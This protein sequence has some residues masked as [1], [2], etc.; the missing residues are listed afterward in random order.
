MIQH[1]D[2]H[3]GQIL[4][5][6]LPNIQVPRMAHGQKVPMDD[7][8]HGI[9]T[10]IIDLGLSRMDSDSAE[11]EQVHWTPLEDEIFEGEGGPLASWG[12][13]CSSLRPQVTTNL[14]YTE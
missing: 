5:K 1:R 8:A 3:W 4:V 14:T 11:V 12:D 10:T 13:L 2:L 6:N 9:E 7:I